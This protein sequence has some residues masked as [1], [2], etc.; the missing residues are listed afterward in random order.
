MNE[1]RQAFVD[2]AGVTLRLATGAAVVQ[3]W[4]EPSR[5]EGMTVGALAVHVV[6]AGITL[7]EPYLDDPEPPGTR[8]FDASRFYSGLSQDLQAD[9]HRGVR[10]DADHQA[11]GGPETLTGSAGQLDSLARRLGREPEARRVRVMNG[12]D[13]TL[14]GFL[15]T[16]LVELVV[17]LDD[18]AASVDV[19]TPEV[20]A[21]ATDLVV[22]CLT[23]VARRR[24]GDVMVIRA[25]ARQGWADGVL[26]IF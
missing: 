14:D 4:N 8:A 17:H 5:L 21:V 2:A 23:G 7:V 11:E 12:I 6:R 16:R 25:L 20:P 19:P 26:P 24:H 22:A 9:V 10:N 1:T 15:V 13:M 3:G 18:L